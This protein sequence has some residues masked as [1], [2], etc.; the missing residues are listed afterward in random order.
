[1]TVNCHELQVEP[2]TAIQTSETTF[3]GKTLHLLSPMTAV[4][5]KKNGFR[6]LPWSP[7]EADLRVVRQFERPQPSP[8]L[9]K[10]VEGEKLIVVRHMRRTNSWASG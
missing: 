7:R 6:F 5:G 1:M 10:N 9:S 2:V 8:I 4:S 3:L